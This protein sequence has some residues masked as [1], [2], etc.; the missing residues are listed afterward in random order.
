[1]C[2][3]FKKEVVMVHVILCT[4]KLCGKG[5]EHVVCFWF[6]LSP[7]V[8]LVLLVPESRSISVMYDIV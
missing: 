3:P 1:M 5:D 7:G 2:V 4:D 6:L 8:F